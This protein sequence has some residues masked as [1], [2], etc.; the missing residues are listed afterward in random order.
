MLKGNERRGPILKIKN[1]ERFNFKT[2]RNIRKFRRRIHA[3]YSTWFI[4]FN[5][6]T[7]WVKMTEFYHHNIECATK[8]EEARKQYSHYETILKLWE[9]KRVDVKHQITSRQWRNNKINK[10]IF[11]RIR[12][13]RETNAADSFIKKKANRSRCEGNC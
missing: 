2:I 8:T 6:D 11:E 7:T 5:C 10:T 4:I 13:S 3:T 1:C 12:E 9:N